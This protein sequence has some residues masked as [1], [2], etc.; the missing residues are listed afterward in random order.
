MIYNFE[1]QQFIKSDLQTVWK[2]FNNPKH[3]HALTTLKMQLKTRTQNL[4][5]QIHKNL[6]ISYWVSPLFGIPL[7]WKT[8]ITNVVPN[9][10]FIDIQIKGPYKIWHHLHTFKQVKEGVLMK[11]FI[12][13]QLPLG[14]IGNFIHKIL[15]K[16]EIENLFEFRTKQVQKHFEN[17]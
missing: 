5:N 15:V 12:T 1:D 9:E 13:Y 8:K 16:K 14:F 2:Y 3:I 7:K 4:P 10:S 11:D 17:E 6:I